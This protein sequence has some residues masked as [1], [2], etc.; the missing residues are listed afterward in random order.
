MN[1]LEAIKMQLN[2]THTENGDVAYESTGSACLDFF[3]LCGGM[4][5]N[6]AAL[7]KLFAKAYAENPLLAIKILFYMRN[8]RGGLGERKNF[9]MLL[10]EVANLDPEMAKQIA[11]AVPEYGRW[12][13]LLVLL[14]TPAKDAA[15]ALIKAQIE[16]DKKVVE[17]GGDPSAG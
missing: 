12:D 11:Y 6:P 7:D 10:K 5:K 14:E 3:S 15:I 1:A 17:K 4:R 8:I 9:R 16:K 2:V 13:D